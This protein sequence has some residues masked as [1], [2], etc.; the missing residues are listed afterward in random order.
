MIF[1]VLTEYTPHSVLDYMSWYAHISLLGIWREAFLFR[2]PNVHLGPT[3]LRPDWDLHQRSGTIEIATEIVNLEA[4]DQFYTLEL[5]VSDAGR[6][7]HRTTLT[8]DVGAARSAHRRAAL[9]VP[10]VEPWSAEVPRLYDLDITLAIAGGR[11][12]SRGCASC[13]GCWA[14]QA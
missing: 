11:A 6:L 3:D 8:G 9:Q 12:S 10:D 5:S 14:A 13:S 2:V 7:L 4:R 1:L